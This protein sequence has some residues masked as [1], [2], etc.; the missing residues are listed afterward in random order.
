VAEDWTRAEVE[1]IV[2]DYFSMLGLELQDRPYSK[3]EHRR[4]LKPLLTRNELRF[5]VDHSRQFHLYRLFHFRKDPRFF[6]LNGRHDQ[7]CTLDP[8]QFLARVA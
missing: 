4:R 3:A 8:T 6:A 2:R 1:A 7:T 5:S